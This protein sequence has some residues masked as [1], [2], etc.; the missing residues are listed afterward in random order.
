MTTATPSATSSTTPLAASAKFK[1]FVIVYAIVHPVTYVI[2]VIL[3]LP[4]F[5]Y[6]PA[7][8]RF[9]LGWEAARSGEG[10]NMTWYGWVATTV[11]VGLI[12]GMAATML[13]ERMT[14]K[15]PLTLVWLLPMLAIPIMAYT[16]MFFWTHP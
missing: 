4:L 16:L 14:N 5:T 10:P 1:T 6:H 12:V 9:A 13:P 7:T 2:C 3:Q 15:L 8:N 11:L